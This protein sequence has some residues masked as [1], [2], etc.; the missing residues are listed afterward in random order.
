MVKMFSANIHPCN[1]K[2]TILY[3]DKEHIKTDQM[4]YKD[5]NFVAS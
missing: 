1:L 4:L 5:R 3:V 2:G